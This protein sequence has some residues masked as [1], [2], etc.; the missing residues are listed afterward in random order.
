[1]GNIFQKLKNFFSQTEMEIVLV[2]LEGSGKTTLSSQ[3]SFGKPSNKGP[4]LGLDIRTF[5]KEQ[6]TM[7]MWDL[8]GQKK[9]RSEWA[10]YAVGSDAILF[11]VDSADLERI[12][13]AKEELHRMLDSKMLKG[14]PLL[15]VGNKIDLLGHLNQNDIIESNNLLYL[16]ISLKLDDLF[17]Y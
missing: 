7:K 16:F 14:V 10:K 13:Q 2:G 11:V 1:M 17:S 4:T 3:L 8:G 5:K 12:S 15:V 6:V 9:Y